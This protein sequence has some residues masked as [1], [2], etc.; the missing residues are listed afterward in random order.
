MILRLH[1]IICSFFLLGMCNAQQG[2]RGA[3]ENP[4]DNDI[5]PV[6]TYAI[7][8]G[9][10]DYKVVPHLQYAH[11][12]AK[13]FEAFLLSDA[14]GKVPKSNIETFI[15]ERATRTNVGDAISI[16]RSKAK[17]HDR[18]YFFFAGHGDMED[19][20]QAENGLLLLYNSPNGNYFGMTDDV[21]QI[22]N[23]KMY[24]SPLAEQGIEMVFIIDACH[25]G[26][27]TGGIAGVRQTGLALMG[28]WGREYKILSCQPAQLSLESEAYGGGRGLF[29]LEFEEG[30]KGLADADSNGMVSM[31]ELQSYV[32][33]NVAKFSENKQ[34]PLITGDLSKS[35][36]KV[37]PKI[38]AELK[39]QK[40][41]N[42]P[43]LA[44]VNTKG[45]LDKYLD[46]LDPF[47]KKIYFSFNQNLIDKK[48]VWPIDTNAFKVISMRRELAA[49]LTNRFNII[50]EPQLKGEP[51]YATRDE[52]Y[53]A[54]MELDSCLQLLGSQHYMYPNLKARKL[55]MNAMAITWGLDET[56]YNI[57]LKPQV[58][59]SIQLLEESEKLEPN[60]SYTLSALGTRY[61][62][63]YEYD[64]A[65]QSFQKFLDL[66][67][68]DFYAKYSLALLFTKL[69][70]YD[71]AIDL[72]KKLIIERT[73]FLGL[74][75]MLF[76][77][78]V[79]NNNV[80]EALAYA[81]HIKTSVDVLT[82]NFCIGLLYAQT[83][84]VD[85]AVYYY[86]KCGQILPN[87][88]VC[89]NN[90]GVVYFVNNKIDSATKYFKLARL[91]DTA[92]AFPHFN[93][94]TI[95][96]RNA[97]YSAAINGF[98]RSLELSP[99]FKEGFVN[100]LD[101]YFNKQYTNTSTKAFH[102]FSFTTFNFDMQYLNYTSILY[103]ILRDTANTYKEGV[104]DKIFVL[105][106]NYKNH[107]VFTWYHN[108]C[109]KA[110]KNDKNAALESIQKALELGFGS[111][112]MLTNDRDLALIQNTSEFKTLLHKYFPD[113]K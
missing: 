108:A 52:C 5:Q 60:V 62:F 90:I 58:E 75:T 55:Y 53:Y 8:I 20:K 61:I 46:S 40:A 2:K 67:P 81:R 15:N 102:D 26:N 19:L 3:V 4:E 89:Y 16:V 54:A 34:I 88:T 42:Y 41:K 82:G 43:M 7:I 111:Y 59:K 98:S 36:F 113:G 71:K 106:H 74:H 84:K 11:K 24:L 87:C 49:A 79:K 27:L 93:L 29:S 35:F 78:Y 76:D 13:A 99:S 92:D 21:L 50:V 104:L 72:L 63:V 9:I 25:S 73:D 85:S 48:L 14:G 97:D 109:Y 30:V 47:F 6:N 100:H 18:V 86:K 39:K 107:D 23:L 56:Q 65:F 96:A 51:S 28:S 68:K 37:D 57:G 33:A 10:S 91:S 112:Y 94:A 1:L 110:L 31:F 80:K 38:L 77:A 101:L 105:M 22:L 70:Q 95:D 69:K 45:S 12:D 17:P 83:A 64:K 103:C 66:R 44:P 32:Q